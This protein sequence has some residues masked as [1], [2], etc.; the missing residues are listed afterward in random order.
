MNNLVPVV[1][2][3]VNHRVDHALADGHADPM[4]LV[5]IETDIRCRAQNSGLSIINALECGRIIL[6]QQCL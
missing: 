5:L 4:L 2:I 6:I 3:P 1:S